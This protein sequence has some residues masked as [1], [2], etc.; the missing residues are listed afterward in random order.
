MKKCDGPM[1]MGGKSAG[2]KRGGFGKKISGFG[3]KL[4]KGRMG[5]SGMIAGPNK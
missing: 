4:G 3:G 2:A 1:N 5:K